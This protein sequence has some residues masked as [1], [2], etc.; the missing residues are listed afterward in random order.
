MQT[1]Y[2]CS[3]LGSDGEVEEV[4]KANSKDKKACEKDISLSCT[5]EMIKASC[6]IG[7]D[8]RGD[9]TKME[10]PITYAESCDR[11][12]CICNTHDDFVKIAEERISSAITHDER[13]E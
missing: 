12:S 7:P 9:F 13:K 1:R 3:Q 5:C 11:E 10:V 6:L 2:L 8:S 4:I